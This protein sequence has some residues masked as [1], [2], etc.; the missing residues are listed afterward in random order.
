MELMDALFTRRS[1]RKYQDR[2]IPPELIQELLAAA[3]A[4]PN[5]GNAQA[6][7]FVV[8]TD[9]ALLDRVPGFSPYA[10]MARNAP[11]GI[12]VCGDLSLEKYPG[13]WVQDCSAAMQNLLLAAHDKGLGAV[14]TGVHPMQDRVDGFRAL[15]GLPGHVVPLGFA[16]L[17]YPA[18]EA[19][20]EDRFRQDR[21][22]MNGW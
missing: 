10:A 8:V 1:I 2:P 11:A 19:R 14:W 5:A 3:M 4:A 7:Q 22:H 13:Y 16:V 12:L 18:Q 21:V 9:R 20:R 6:W 17:G 15:L